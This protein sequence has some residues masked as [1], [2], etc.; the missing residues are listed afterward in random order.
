MMSGGVVQVL[1][2]GGVLVKTYSV[3]GPGESPW[4]YVPP[5]PLFWVMGGLFLLQGIF[6]VVTHDVG[7]FQFWLYLVMGLMGVLY[8][9]LVVSSR[10]RHRR[11]VLSED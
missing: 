4:W 3:P 9:A 7:E 2:H 10:R 5:L 6:G 8:L 11:L 1:D